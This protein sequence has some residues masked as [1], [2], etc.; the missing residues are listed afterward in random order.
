MYKKLEEFREIDKHCVHSIFS[1]VRI[2]E[3]NSMIGSNTKANIIVAW[4]V[5][6]ALQELIEQA[7][8]SQKLE[9]R[10]GLLK[11][12]YPNNYYYYHASP[13]GVED[14]KRWLKHIIESV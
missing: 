3:L 12:D 7:I 2:Q 10:I 13:R 4:G 6:N 1:E 11:Q 14:K 8:R 9:N 5:N